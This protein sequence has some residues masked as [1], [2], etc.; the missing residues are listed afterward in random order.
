MKLGSTGRMYSLPSLGLEGTAS[1]R[2]SSASYG[3]LGGVQAKSLSIVV[4]ATVKIQ[5][6]V[7]TNVFELGPSFPAEHTT[8]IPFW[9][10]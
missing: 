8:S 4:A 10:A 2:Y 7:F 3:S 5:G 9:V 1:G 6:A